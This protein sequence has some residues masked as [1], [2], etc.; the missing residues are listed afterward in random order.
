MPVRQGVILVGGLGTRL[1]GLTRSLPKPMLEVAGRPFVEHVMA[2]ITRFAIDKIL[3]LAGYR[4]EVFADTYAGRRLF[5]ASV[6]VVIEPEPLG[7]AGG[8]RFAADRLDNSFLLTNGD[9]FFDSDLQPLVCGPDEEGRDVTVLLRWV[10]DP[11]R[12]GRVTLSGDRIELF[13]EKSTVGVI[14]GALI[15]AGTYRMCRDRVLAEIPAGS[16]SLERD[17]LPSIARRG[18]AAG[19]ISSGFFVDMGIPDALQ[20]ARSDLESVRLRPAAFLDRDGVLNVDNGY[21]HRVEDLKLMPDVVKAVRLLN[22]AG[23]YVLVVSNQAGIARGYYSEDQARVFNQALRVELLKSGAR[24]DAVYYCPHH[25]DGVEHAYAGVCS[26][27]KPAPGL[28]RAAQQDWPIDL[29][30][31]FL[32]G[33]SRSDLE[34]AAA[35]GIPAYHYKGGSLLNFMKSV[36]NVRV[37]PV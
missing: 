7:T 30:H 12:Y 22:D 28:I 15:N 34:A 10:D 4:G 23:Y 8:L 5:G 24:I 31:S 2:H 27:R 6:D 17:V 11:G 36:L 1:G 33:D 32:V 25:P 14:R 19:H 18:R 20:R 35:V 29:A 16:S 26:C 13:D 9:T 21:T 37:P 3:L